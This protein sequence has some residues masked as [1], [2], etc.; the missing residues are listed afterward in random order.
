MTHRQRHRLRRFSPYFTPDAL[1]AQELTARIVVEASDGAGEHPVVDDRYDHRQAVYR[2]IAARRSRCD[3]LKGALEGTLESVFPTQRR[4][5]RRL[6]MVKP[7]YTA[8]RFTQGTGCQVRSPDRCHSGIPGH[9][10]R[11]RHRKGDRDAR[12]REAE[13]VVVR[14]L[15]A[16]RSMTSVRASLRRQSAA[17]R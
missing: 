1:F 16:G 7:E 5:I 17:R 9:E 13:I 15:V 8:Q 11:V 10:L 12:A 14:N 2:R 6:D 3:E 4:G